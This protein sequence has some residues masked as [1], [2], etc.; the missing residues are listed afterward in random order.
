MQRDFFIL[1]M[2][3]HDFKC[4]GRAVFEVLKNNGF[5]LNECR[6]GRYVELTIDSPDRAT[7]L[8]K[9]EKMAEFVLYNPLIETFH[10]EV[11][12]K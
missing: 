2:G 4:Q 3:E 10:A 5:E 1:G 9:A 11:I 7:A 6:V 8:E 12:E